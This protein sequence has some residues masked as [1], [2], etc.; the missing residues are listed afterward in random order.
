MRENTLAFIS[1]HI[2]KTA[3]SSFF[4]SLKYAYGAESVARFEF[5][6]RLGI[7]QMNQMDYQQRELPTEKTVLHGHFPVNKL[8]ELFPNSAELPLVVWLRNPVDRIISDYY[9]HSQVL[10]DQMKDAA[11]YEFLLTK[12]LKSIEEYASAAKMTNKLSLFTRG[13]A[14]SDFYF[15]GI[16]E[17]YESDLTAFSNLIGQ[18]L[19]CYRSNESSG[20]RAAI[21]QHVRDFIIEN[22]KEDMELYA[23]ALSLRKRRLGLK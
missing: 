14:L 1:I 23:E 18:Q 8:F 10:K 22:N 2:P 9:Y 13:K 16:T 19:T 21:P 17:H 11:N 15:V 5:R 20:S 6:P 7:V 3:G 4:E 12:M